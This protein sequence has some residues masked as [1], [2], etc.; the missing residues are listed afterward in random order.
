[1]VLYDGN[2]IVLDIIVFFAVGRL[3]RHKSV[4]NLAWT[5]PAACLAIFVSLLASNSAGVDH[6]ITPYEIR[7]TWGWE[8]WTLVGLFGLPLTMGLVVIHFVHAFRNGF[9]V[10][11]VVE[12]S[13]TL[14]IFLAP[15]TQSSFFHLH[16][17]YYAWF[18]G[19]HANAD[20]WWSRLTMSLLWGL[21]INGV[22]IF[23]R[24]P[25]MTC[26]VTLYQS[27]NQDCPY[28]VDEDFSFETLVASTD[29]PLDC[30]SP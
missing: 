12:L 27:Q 5:L 30:D 20:V 2:H 24:D 21:Y 6:S 23:G 25:I 19:M 9:G 1:M 7:C 16:H 11:K 28:L 8:M 13:V 17:W 10:Q 18:L 22:A 14:L 26:A 29:R 15:Y 4:D 3:Y